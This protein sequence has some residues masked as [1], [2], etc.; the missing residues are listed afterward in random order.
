MACNFFEG[1]Q[2]QEEEMK[3]K[4]EEEGRGVRGGG[5]KRIIELIFTNKKNK[6]V[7]FCDYYW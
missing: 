2:Y 5:A 6:K 1:G 4:K 7:R 3:G